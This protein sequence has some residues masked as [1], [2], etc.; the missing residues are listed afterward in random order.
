[1]SFF[2][3][4]LGPFVN[5]AAALLGAL[6]GLTVRR[7]P[8]AV[9][10]IVQQSLGAASG[11]IGVSMALE[12]PNFLIVIASLATG[13]ALGQWLQ[14]EERLER[15]AERARARFGGGG[16]FVEG[17]VLATLVWCVG[18]MAVLGSMQSGLTGRDTILFTKSAL[19]GTSAIFFAAALGPGVALA[20]LPLFLYEA[21]IAALATLVA[22]L[23]GP[24]VI[25]PLTYVGG[26]LIALIG[27]NMLGATRIKVGNLLPSIFIAMLLGGA[28]AHLSLRL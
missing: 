24:D 22:P 25:A 11:L 23:L 8:E 27:A 13:A 10:N 5:G 1:M 18:A 16:S 28:A 20:A 14:L 19:D 9:R 26:V 17:F 15:F 7:I 12:R 4:E 6:I 3:H 21:L 2:A